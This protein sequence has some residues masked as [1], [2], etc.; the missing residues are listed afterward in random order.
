M[1]RWEIKL[2]GFGGQ[3]V[4]LAGHILGQAA[5]LYDKKNAVLTQSYG[6]ESRGGGC[7]VDLVVD[8]GAI[9]YP[10][11][12]E[13]Q[14]VVAMSQEAYIK[15][16]EELAPGGVL[17]VDAD[18]V[19]VGRSKGKRVYAIP[20]TRLAEEMGHKIGAN[21][22]MLGAFCALTEIIS[23]EAMQEAIRSMVPKGTEDLNLRAFQRGYDYGKRLANRRR[24]AAINPMP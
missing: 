6:P 10:L 23:P 19:K 9:L 11:V 2:A 5:T 21:I 22:V 18:L 7:S 12:M 13:P 16:A 20:A 4:I 3:G 17:L 24:S 8:E 14:V 1:S 15:Y